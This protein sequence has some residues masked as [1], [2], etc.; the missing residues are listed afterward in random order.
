MNSI[1]R[2]AVIGENVRLG[3][4]NVVEPY[5]VI[6]GN[7]IIGDNNWIGPHVVIGAPPEHREHHPIPFIN[8]TPGQI[9]I[10]SRNVIHEHT[11]IQ[12]PTV[13]IT[14]IGS[15]CF[16]MH[17]C[18]VAHDCV[19]E[20][21]VTIAP[22]SVL[23]GHVYVQAR[24]TLG[25]GTVIHQRRTIGA[26]ALTGMNATVTRDVIP[27]MTVSGTPAKVLR[28]NSVG[29]ERSSLPMGP[30]LEELSLDFSK[31]NLSIFPPPVIE[32]VNKFIQE[33]SKI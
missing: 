13:G 10:G 20:D 14:A 12:S 33:T 23:G 28:P 7:V 19:I 25:I 4:G 5:A 21:W 27:F 24:A 26:F 22:T 18:H 2:T 1:H 6:T 3:T 8:F 11:S 16:I 29:I 30:W 31:W 9:V 32:I 15:N 17:A